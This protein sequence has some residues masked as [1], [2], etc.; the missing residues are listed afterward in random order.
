VEV[1]MTDDN[2][3]VTIYSIE[4]PE[5]P[6]VKT[7]VLDEKGRMIYRKAVVGYTRPLFEYVV[8]TDDKA[9]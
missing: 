9:E 5:F 4:A 3:W 1:V 7:N 2:F 6:L 8:K